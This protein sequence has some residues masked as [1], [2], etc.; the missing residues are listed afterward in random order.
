MNEDRIKNSL[1]Q[2]SIKKQQLLLALCDKWFNSLDI[3]LD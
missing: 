3:K 2:Q 1:D